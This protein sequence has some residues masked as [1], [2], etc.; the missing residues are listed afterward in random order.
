MM[1]LVAMAATASLASGLTRAAVDG[2]G[3]HKVITFLRHG[4]AMHNIN[5]ERLK[6]EGCSHEVFLNAMKVDDVFDAPLTP[7]GVAQAREAASSAAAAAA[8]AQAELV[9]S[10]PLSRALDTADL[11]FPP[12]STPDAK[13][14]CVEELREI[15]GWL[16]NAQ[17]KPASKLKKEYAHW[18]FDEFGLAEEGRFR[19]CPYGRRR[20]KLSSLPLLTRCS[21]SRVAQHADSLWTEALEREEDCTARA[22]RVIEMLWQRPERHICVVAHGGIFALLFNAGEPLDSQGAVERLGGVPAAADTAAAVAGLDAG[23]AP[24]LRACPASRKR[25]ENCELRT[26]ELRLVQPHAGG[27]ANGQREFE[28]RIVR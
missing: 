18:D 26:V 17:R 28:V 22:M 15:N 5:A 4:Q 20:A 24:T 21:A 9:V 14:C 2:P 27:A 10:S 6:R 16:I 23:P 3:G 1:K 11:V 19:S 25:F 8:A 12:E 13:R 7:T